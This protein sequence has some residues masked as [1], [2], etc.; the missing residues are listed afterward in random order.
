MKILF[1][2][3][4][5][6]EGWPALFCRCEDCRRARKLGGKNIRTRASLQLGSQYKVDFPPD[7]YF[8][9]LKYGLFYADLEHLFITHTHQDHL[10]ALDLRM[11]EFPFSF[12]TLKKLHIYGSESVYQEIK[13]TI[14]DLGKCKL[15]LR[16]VEP[17]E[18]FKAGELEVTPILA[19]HDPKQICLNYIFR[20]NNKTILQA[21]DTG[22]YSEQTWKKL[23]DYFF[24][25]VIMDCTSGG[26]EKNI[27]PR[28]HLG[29]K[30]LI[31]VKKRMKKMGILSSNCFFI[32]THFSHGGK[33]MH[34]ELKEKL[35]PWG[36]TVA[37]D[38]MEVEI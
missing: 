12:I 11:R 2:G 36:I 17:F 16:V 13:E 38:G 8:Q 22:W 21:F 24:D 28:N 15:A 7:S 25:I 34:H 35:N 37:Y 19:N 10:Y 6:A 18:N 23:A 14:K 1:L 9:M 29:V 3:T 4:A 33:L 32:A 31:E 27:H 5:A 20:L 30:S 26:I